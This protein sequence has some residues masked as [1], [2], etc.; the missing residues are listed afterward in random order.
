MPYHLITIVVT[1]ASH[2][3]VLVYYLISM[4]R[5]LLGGGLEESKVFTLWAV[6]IVATIVIT[7]LGIILTTIML[8]IVRA[9]K[10]GTVEDEDFIVDERDKLIDLKGERVAYV[11]S[12]FGVFL[13][14]LTFVFDQPALV[15]FSLLIL[16]GIVA[17]VCGDLSKLYYYRR[18]S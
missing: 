9:A 10:T 2:L 7:V 8:S 18:G 3:V 16:V 11:A 4:G 12:T 13:A 17:G 14:M 1:L 5:M 6:V 15:M